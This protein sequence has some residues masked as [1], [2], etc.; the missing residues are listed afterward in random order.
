MVGR[1]WGQRCG[2]GVLASC[3][4]MACISPVSSTSPA[5]DAECPRDG[6]GDRL[7]R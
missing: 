2:S 4:M 5:R 6:G 1:P 7:L 3:S